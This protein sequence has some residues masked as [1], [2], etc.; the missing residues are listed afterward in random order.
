MGRKQNF[1]SS[2]ENGKII[3]NFLVTAMKSETIVWSGSY[4]FKLNIP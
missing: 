4:N 3:D 2:K 1:K